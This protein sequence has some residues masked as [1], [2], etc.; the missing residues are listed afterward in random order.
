[1]RHV[2]SSGSGHSTREPLLDSVAAGFDSCVTQ[3]NAD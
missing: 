1:M 3:S 2:T